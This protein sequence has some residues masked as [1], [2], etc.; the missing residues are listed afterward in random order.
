MYLYS[1]LHLFS[2]FLSPLNILNILVLCLKWVN[3]IRNNQKYTSKHSICPSASMYLYSLLHLFSHFLSPLN[4]LNI[5][6]LCLKWVNNIRNNQ[7]ITKYHQ[8]ILFVHLPLCIYIHYCTFPPFF[9]PAGKP[10][11]ESKSDGYTNDYNQWNQLVQEELSVNAKSQADDYD[12][13]LT[14]EVTI[15][16]GDWPEIEVIFPS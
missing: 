11:D 15:E 6:V 13:E 9:K 16:V 1:L 2:H 5:L 10:S 3:N 4:I 12:K 7:K 8:S 14:V